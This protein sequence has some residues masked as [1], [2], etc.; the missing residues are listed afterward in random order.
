M[1]KL[2]DEKIRMREVFMANHKAK[3]KFYRKEG[4]MT[5]GR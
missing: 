2:T 3:S 1:K 4:I 5:Y